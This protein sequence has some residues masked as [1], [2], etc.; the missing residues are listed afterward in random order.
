MSSS[1][2]LYTI[3]SWLDCSHAFLTEISWKCNAQVFLLHPIRW[4]I[5]LICPTTAILSLF[6]SLRR[7]LPIFSTVKLFF[8][9]SKRFYR[10]SGGGRGVLGNCSLK[11]KLHVYSFSLNRPLVCCFTQWIII[12]CYHY[13]LV[14]FYWGNI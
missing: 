14:C 7:C 5:I 4:L 8:S 2:G 11:K 9:P 10:F 13:L 12:H 3:S 1:L 6:T